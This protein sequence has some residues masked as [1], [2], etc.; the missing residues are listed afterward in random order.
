MPAAGHAPDHM[1][2]SAELVRGVR[3]IALPCP[4]A[5][6][7]LMQD[8]YGVCRRGRV[9]RSFVK[10]EAMAKEVF[11]LERLHTHV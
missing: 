3:A 4:L 2:Y 8:G 11:F 1:G 5:E 10:V 7:L 9:P 6:C